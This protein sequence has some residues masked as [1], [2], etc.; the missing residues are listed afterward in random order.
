MKNLIQI[1]NFKFKITPFKWVGV[2]MIAVVPQI[3]LS[4]TDYWQQEVRYNIQVALNDKQHSLK[5]DLS[6]E[7]INHSPDTLRY[8]WFYLWPNAYRNKN[9]AFAKQLVADKSDEKKTAVVNEPGFID[10]LRFT[11]NGQTTATESDT[12]NID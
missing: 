7:Y 9:T 11:I 8:I 1:M 10:S 5:G 6:V 3:A 4:Q 12:A 2:L